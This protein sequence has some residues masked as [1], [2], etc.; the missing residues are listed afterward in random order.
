MFIILGGAATC[1]EGFVICFLLLCST[2]A[3]K[4]IL[5]NLWNKW[6]P[7][8][9]TCSINRPKMHQKNRLKSKMSLNCLPVARVHPVGGDDCGGGCGRGGNGCGGWRAVDLPH[10]LLLVHFDA[11]DP[12]LRL[13]ASPPRPALSLFSDVVNFTALP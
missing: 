5:Q 12:D 8:L 4:N 10:L 7:H 1:S 13:A 11:G 2:A 3:A 6:P 9:V